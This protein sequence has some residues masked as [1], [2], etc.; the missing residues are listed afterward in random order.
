MYGTIIENSNNYRNNFTK[1]YYD[2]LINQQVD[3]KEELKKHF[4]TDKDY[5]KADVILCHSNAQCQEYNK[6]M[7][8]FHKLNKFDVGAKIICTTNTCK[9]LR[10]LGIYNKFAYTIVKYDYNTVYLDDTDA[11]GN[12]ICFNK[13]LLKSNFES[14]YAMNFYNAQGQQFKNIYVPDS[15]INNPHMSGR[16]A[17]TIISRLKENINKDFIIDFND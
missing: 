4:N 13:S 11:T 6:L 12:Q 7:L 5:T 8:A 14:N 1:E 16:M 10:G 9:T 3:I 2:S 15:S 17:Y